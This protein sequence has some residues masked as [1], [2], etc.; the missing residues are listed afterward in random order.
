MFFFFFR[1]TKSGSNECVKNASS[2]NI[3]PPIVSAKLTT[4]NSFSVLYGQ[5][6]VVAKLPIGDWIASGKY[7]VTFY[8]INIFYNLKK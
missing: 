2:F 4:K 8:L 6:E 1:C 3:I 7:K 5:L